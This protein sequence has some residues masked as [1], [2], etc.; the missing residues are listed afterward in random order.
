MVRPGDECPAC[1]EGTLRFKLLG[2]KG[3]RWTCTRCAAALDEPANWSQTEP[4][5]DGQADVVAVWAFGRRVQVI[6]RERKLTQLQLALRVGCHW[7][8]IAAIEQG[9]VSPRLRTVLRVA[10]ALRVNPADL[11]ID[12]PAGQVPEADVQRIL[13]TSPCPNCGADV[14]MRCG[15][16]VHPNRELTCPGC[17]CVFYA[18]PRARIEAIQRIEER[19]PWLGDDDAP[20]LDLR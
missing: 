2:A 13:G 20:V 16:G 18:T 15:S 5:S 6:R 9:E 14:P 3:T 10:R 4:E 19:E 11:V 7:A 8:V 17:E 12:L 1:E